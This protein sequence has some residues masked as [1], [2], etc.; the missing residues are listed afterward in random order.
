MNIETNHIA[1]VARLIP[2]PRAIYWEDA[3]EITP[4]G[5]QKGAAVMVGLT[6]G[7]A[8]VAL[9]GGKAIGAGMLLGAIG[10]GAAYFAIERFA[11]TA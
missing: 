9:S 6:V 8:V 1:N 5:A 10:A 2:D 7:I 4:E 11:K 3:G